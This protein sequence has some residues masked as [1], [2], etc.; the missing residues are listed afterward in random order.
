MLEVRTRLG[1]VL[2]VS[3]IAWLAGCS[4]SGESKGGTP[5]DT[6]SDCASNECNLEA[7]VCVELPDGD[8]LDDGDT[9]A[10]V[11]ALDPCECEEGCEDITTGGG[12]GGGGGFDPED[13]DSDGVG[14]NP[15]GELV[16][17]STQINTRIIWIANTMQ[18]TVAKVDTTT[19]EELGRYQTGPSGPAADFFEGNDPSRTSVNTFS[20]VYVGN[21]KGKS[22]VKISV[23]GDRCP[24]QNNDGVVTTSTGVSDIKP[25][26]SGEPTDECILWHVDLPE[27]GNGLVRAVAA[28]EVAGLDGALES[29]V[30]VGVWDQSGSND[31]VYKLDGDTGAIL[32]NVKAPVKPYGFALDGAGNLWISHYGSHNFGRI[33]TTTCVDSEDCDAEPVCTAA[34]EAAG[35][36]CV[37]QVLSHPSLV[38]YGITVDQNQRVWLGGQRPQRYDPSQPWGSRFTEIRADGANIAAL[39]RGIGASTSFAYL[40]LDSGDM[41]QVPLEDPAAGVT[42][43]TTA[44]D[45]YGIAI[46]LDGKVWGIAKG[47]AFATVVTP[48]ATLGDV[49]V[50]DGPGG[51]VSPYTYSDMTGSQLRLA[52]NPRGYYREQYAGCTSGVTEWRSL[53]YDVETPPGTSVVFRVRTAATEM[54]LGAADWVTVAAIPDDASPADV[55]AALDAAEVAQNTYLEVEVQ[56]ISEANSL[57]ESIT[58]VVKSFGVTRTC[59]VVIQ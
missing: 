27:P 54:A 20:D 57:E 52:T 30:W 25:W 53:F 46:D 28:Q 2:A 47:R 5:C 32:L 3:T 44:G 45:S 18:G 11:P 29:Y 8:V 39:G 40:A 56:L 16:L 12:G 33:N 35:N 26:V 37:K 19:F 14:T 58:P 13:D 1:V 21:R 50:V 7:G 10:C 38:P 9:G 22:V 48:T 15:D 51:L 4:C 31:R 43:P 42:I 34:M 59:P 55:A 17:D 49:A 6:A 24:D 36:A 23:L 41:V